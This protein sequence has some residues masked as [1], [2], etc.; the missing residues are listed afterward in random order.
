M[1]DAVWFIFK[2]FLLIRI[3]ENTHCLGLSRSL[4]LQKLSQQ[5]SLVDDSSDLLSIDRSIEAV[6]CMQKCMSLLECTSFNY[7]IINKVCEFI[8]EQNQPISLTSVQNWEVY[9]NVKTVTQKGNT[10]L[11]IFLS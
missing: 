5:K 7:D 9:R 10:Y 8:R 3:S 6:I 4:Y 11:C 1:W 2:L